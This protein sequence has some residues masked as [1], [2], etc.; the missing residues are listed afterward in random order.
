MKVGRAEGKPEANIYAQF[1]DANLEILEPRTN[2]YLII[3]HGPTRQRF[4]GGG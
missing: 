1:T 3:V 2:E 4:P